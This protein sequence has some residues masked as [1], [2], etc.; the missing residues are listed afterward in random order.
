MNKV[1]SSHYTIRFNDCD[2]FGHLNN[3]RYLDY[4]IN[5]R[6]DH[7]KEAYG[8]ELTDY[9][10]RGEGWVVGG[11]EINYVRPAL[12]YERVAIRSTLLQMD[13]AFLYVEAVM[14]DE[15]CTHVKAIMRTRL[16]PINIQTGKKIPHKPEFM[17]WA[18]EI[19]NT[20]LDPQTSIQQRIAE[21]RAELE[22]TKH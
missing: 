2:M 8:F 9:Y 12:C 4:L 16:V 10:K 22:M 1:P 19:V 13:E 21:L 5:A 14:M 11:H 6:E 15:G 20:D 18:K 3:S 7:L 17:E